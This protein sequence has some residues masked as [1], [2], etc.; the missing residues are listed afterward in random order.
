MRALVLSLLGTAWMAAADNPATMPVPREAEWIRRHEG[1]VADAKKGGV[2]LLFIG[3]S[4]TDDW[5]GAGKKIW[6]ESFAPFR[7]ANIGISGDC[8]QHVLWRLENGEL[9]G[10]EP[11]A[12]VLMIGTNNIGWAGHTP[13]QTIEGIRA[14]VREIVKRTP[15]S[16]ILLLGVFPRDA[17]PDGERRLKIRTINAA[18][19]KLDEG[20]SV[21]FLDIGDKFLSPDGT[22]PADVMPDALH[23]NERGYRIWAEA[24]LG[25][26]K[27]MLGKG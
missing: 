4:I 26:V 22:L 20:K 9:E 17:K 13:E 16:R 1:F 8:T 19:A 5:R 15:R 25:P 23:P 24:I 27:E 18:I 11:K 7:A 3:D 12:I 6:D 14:V 2:D 10:M 21:R